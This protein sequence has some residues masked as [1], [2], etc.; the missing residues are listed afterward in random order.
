MK[1]FP[2]YKV[3]YKFHWQGKSFRVFKRYNLFFY[4]DF[5]SFKTLDDANEYITKWL[6]IH[7][8]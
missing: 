2:M 1:L 3:K 7:R 6:K 4:E 5:V 8:N